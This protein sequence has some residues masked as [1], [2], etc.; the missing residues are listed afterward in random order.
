MNTGSQTD[1]GLKRR[2]FCEIVTEEDWLWSPC[3]GQIFPEGVASTEIWTV[4]QKSWAPGGESRH[5]VFRGCL[6]MKAEVDFV[7]VTSTDA[8]L[9]EQYLFLWGGGRFDR[10]GI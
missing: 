9:W 10:R 6:Q 1:E 8:D 3:R 2:S 4:I 7:Q 5:V